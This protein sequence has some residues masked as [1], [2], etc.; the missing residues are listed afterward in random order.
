[1][2]WDLESVILCWQ[3]KSLLSCENVI[4]KSKFG[5][6]RE[7]SASGSQS[8]SWKDTSLQKHDFEVQCLSTG[9]WRCFTD[10]S[11]ITI[12]LWHLLWTSHVKGAWCSAQIL[13]M[14]PWHRP[15]GHSQSRDVAAKPAT[16]TTLIYS[17]WLWGLLTSF[18]TNLAPWISDLIQALETGRWKCCWIIRFIHGNHCSSQ[19]HYNN[20]WFSQNKTNNLTYVSYQV[21]TII[22]L[23]SVPRCVS[24]LGI[25]PVSDTV[26][27]KRNGNRL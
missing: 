16:A 7:I 22:W 27:C 14:H 21:I 25:C 1:M 15:P 13:P 6:P 18:P 17:V 10:G 12:R 20:N 2:L 4:E 8:I 26:F 19:Y 3:S 23:V 24:N 9:S 5:W 11:H